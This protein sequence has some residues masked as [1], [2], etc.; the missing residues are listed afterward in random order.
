MPEVTLGCAQD[1][2]G[3]AEICEGDASVDDDTVDDDAVDVEIGSRVWV[4]TPD[5]PVQPTRTAPTTSSPKAV[6]ARFRI[7]APG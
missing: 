5:E 3:D 7:P 1:E 4:L 2:L 6:I